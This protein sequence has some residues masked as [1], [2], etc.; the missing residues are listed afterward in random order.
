MAIW[1]RKRGVSPP[2]AATSSDAVDAVSLDGDDHAWWT[3]SEVHEAWRPR[4]RRKAEPAKERDILAEH[5]GDD[6]RTN[7]GFTPPAEATD[8]Y[9][10]LQVDPSATWEEIVEAHRHQ[11]RIHHPDRLFGQSEEEK[12]EGEE[13]IRRVN[14]AYEE[15]QTRRDR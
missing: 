2:E 8:P 6:W 14:A 12:E 11:A 3:Q 15:L 9:E 5:F 4:V 13:R 7:F 10:I 1:S